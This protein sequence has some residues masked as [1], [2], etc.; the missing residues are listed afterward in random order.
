VIERYFYNKQYKYNNNTAL[1]GTYE[2]S[3]KRIDEFS[4]NNKDALVTFIIPSICRESLI[5]TLKSLQNQV[6]NNWK[7]IIVFDGCVPHGN[8]LLELLS[9]NRF[10]YISIN[11]KGYFRKHYHSSAGF[12]RNIGM[13]LVSSA[14]IGFLDDD[15][16]ILENY[17][18]KL[19]E[20]IEYTLGA[21]LISFRM[22]SNNDLIPSKLTNDVILGQIGISFVY[23][24]ELYKNGY[25]FK[26]S[27]Q[28]D[29][30]LI[31]DIKNSKFKIVLSPHITY[32]V[33]NSPVM[34]DNDIIQRTI[35]N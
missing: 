14:Y 8:E 2:D 12:V 19:V 3:L 20:E 23:R 5:R 30:D 11:K 24:T 6:K 35:I 27:E 34:Y 10:L 17:T 18:Q 4:K 9:D 28:E 33:G 15:D 7:A 31:N 29:F 1:E 32:V 13:S 25:M 26:Q 21:D 16:F 22:I